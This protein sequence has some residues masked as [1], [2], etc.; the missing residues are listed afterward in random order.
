MAYGNGGYLHRF[1]GLEAKVIAH[2]IPRFDRMN[3]RD[4]TLERG[5]RLKVLLQAWVVGKAIHTDTAAHHIKMCLRVVEYTRSIAIVVD[6]L[7]REVCF[8]FLL[9]SL[10]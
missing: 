8:Q 2:I 6:N 7:M 5:D 9:E 3:L 10:E 4:D 1:L